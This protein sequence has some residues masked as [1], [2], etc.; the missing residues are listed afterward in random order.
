MLTT[1]DSSTKE[2]TSGQQSE[3]QPIVEA[4]IKDDQDNTPAT[5]DDGS[6]NNVPSDGGNSG[7]QGD[8]PVTEVEEKPAT[9]VDGTQADGTEVVK[10]DGTSSADPTATET[11][12]DAAKTPNDSNG[13][14]TDAAD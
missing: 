5:N 8:K 10:E 14:K 2:P 9:E 11:K 6:D 3:T 1:A 13:T 4:T 12:S 7:D